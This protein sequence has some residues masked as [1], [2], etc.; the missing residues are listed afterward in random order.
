MRGMRTPD[1]PDTEN[2][3]V[4]VR[5]GGV[6]G[7][8]LA[9]ALAREGL[10]VVLSEAAPAPPNDLRAYALNAASVGLLQTLRVW[11]ALP[12]GAATAV[13]DMKVQGDAPAGGSPLHFSAWAQGVE[14]LAWIVDA[15]A[16][17]ATLRD[18]LR[19]SP[20]VRW[21]QPEQAQAWATQVPVALSAICEGKGSDWLA[22]Q[23][24]AVQRRELGQVAVAARLRCSMPHRGVAWQWFLHPDV[25]ALLPLDAVQDGLG[26]ALVWSGPSAQAQ[27]LMQMEE[28]A[29][30]QAL[31]SALQE[32]SGGL[33]AQE[34]GELSL[35]SARAVWPLAH[36]QAQSWC[37]PGWVLLGDAAHG[38][39]PLAGQGL[40][41]GLADVRSLVGVLSAREPWRHMGDEK[42]LRRYERERQTPAW[43]MGLLTDGLMD[44]FAHPSPWAKMLR[45]Q[46]LSWV[47]RAQPLKRWLT[48]QAVGL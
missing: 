26:Y 42:L 27:A 28:P 39:H 43:A 13:L 18:A 31:H 45:N 25:L 38:V 37:G 16:L 48:R 3:T 44:L 46:G 35:A 34:L 14:A 40:N 8:C 24:V 9:L 22:Q 2:P 36:H 11:Q 19:F 6:V 20:H 21:M 10:A 32:A 7:C 4:W 12:A 1:R 23:G 33:A 29:F 15:Q 30:T 17:L 5:G 41:L 47:Q